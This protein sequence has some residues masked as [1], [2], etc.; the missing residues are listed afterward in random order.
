[1]LFATVDTHIQQMIQSEMRSTRDAK[2]YRRLKIIDL[3]GQGTAVPELA[4]LFD[5]TPATIRSYIHVFNA[6]GLD[7]LRPGYGQGRPQAM[8]WTAEQWLDVLSQA[9]CHL[10]LLDT[11]AQNWTQALMRQYLVAYHQLHLSQ[12]ALSKSLHRV[13]LRWRRAKLRVH[14][15]DPL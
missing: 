8:N 12:S 11:A 7:G 14:S 13:G 1:M 2:W 4:G 10:E 3:S 6:H 9:P 15:P 5:L